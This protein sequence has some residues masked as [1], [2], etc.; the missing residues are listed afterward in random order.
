MSGS[1]RFTLDGEQ[2]EARAGET[3]WQVARR[4]GVEIPHLCYTPEPG[5][6]ADANCRLCVVEIEG[7]R[8]LAASCMRRPAAGMQ[9]RTASER[10][11][12]V[13]RTL[14][15]LLLA[16]QPPR[17]LSPDSESR[18]WDWA[19]RLGL[20]VGESRFPKRAAPPADS[21]HPAM[22][23]QLAA[24]I[25]CGLCLRACREVQG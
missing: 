7:E 23:V 10:V 4:H 16:D 25:H 8:A 22:A 9:V 5:Y 6:R 14:M 13:R 15:E 3:R 12:G 18:L 21:S 19:R 2:I 24:C 1:I 11:V 20:G 17:E